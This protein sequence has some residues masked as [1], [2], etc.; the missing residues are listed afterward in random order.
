[1]RPY[2]SGQNIQKQ[3]FKA[4]QEELERGAELGMGSFDAQW[5]L[6]SFYE[7]RGN[8]HEVA[9]AYRK[10]LALEPEDVWANRRYGA[11]LA[12][13][14]ETVQARAFFERALALGPLNEKSKDYLDKLS[15]LR[16]YRQLRKRR[17]PG[18][19]QK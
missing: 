1:M 16:P 13:L 14:G 7:N 4:A 3:K 6:A 5:P 17:T 8:L 9:E 19:N 15:T 18:R 10:C 2:H 12:D 11:V